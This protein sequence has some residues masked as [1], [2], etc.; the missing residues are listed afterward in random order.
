MSVMLSCIEGSNPTF[1]S[2]FATRAKFFLRSGAPWSVLEIETLD[3][4]ILDC[5]GCG[6][7][8]SR[9]PDKQ[10]IQEYIPRCLE[11]VNG[12]ADQ[13]DHGEEM[14]DPP[15]EIFEAGVED[16]RAF[17]KSLRKHRGDN[18]HGGGNDSGTT[19]RYRKK[20]CVVGPSSW[21]KT[22]LIKSLTTNIQT[23]EDTDKRTIGVD[24]F[25]W[26]FAK[27]VPTTGTSA[28]RWNHRVYDVSIWDFAGQDEYQS[29]HTLCYSKRT[30]Y[31]VCI[32]V[33][34][35]ADVLLGS[36]PADIHHD[37]TV[38]AFFDANI[39]SRMRAICV[40]EPES[41]FAFVGT[42]L[43]LITYSRDTIDR[44]E[45]DVT[46]RLAARERDVLR[47]LKEAIVELELEI[48]ETARSKHA[49]DETDGVGHG[50]GL[51]SRIAGLT[52]LQTKR[53]RIL[54]YQLNVMSSRNLTGADTVRLALEDLIVSS[55]TSFIMPPDFLELSAYIHN[56][57]QIISTQSVK[58]QIDTLF[59][60]VDALHDELRAQP[61]FASLERSDI[62]A[63]LRALHVIGDILWFDNADSLLGSTLFLSPALIIDF[64]RKIVNHQLGESDSDP[65][66]AAVRD[67]G[68]VAHALLRSLELWREVHDERLMLQLKS[69]LL[70]FQLAYPDGSSG[71][72]WNSDLIVPIY[73]KKQI[74]TSNCENLE[75]PEDAITGALGERVCWEYEFP[76]EL[77][78]SLFEKLG[79]ASYS[80]HFPCN[81]S[82]SSNAF[83]TTRVGQY[84]AKISKSGIA[85]GRGLLRVTVWA[86]TLTDAWQQLIWYAL[87]IE[88]LLETYL[89]LW[90]TRVAVSRA[91]KRLDIER[92]ITER[93]EAQS[94]SS[95]ICFRTSNPAREAIE[96]LPP[97]IDWY[98]NKS[99]RSTQRASNASKVSLIQS[100]GEAII[101]YDRLEALMV[102]TTL[103][104]ESKFGSKLDKHT[105]KVVY[106][107]NGIH[108]HVDNATQSLMT[109]AAGEGNRREYPALWSLMYDQSNVVKATYELQIRSQL[110]GR[111]FQPKRII[112]SVAGA[113]FGKYGVA[114]NVSCLGSISN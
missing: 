36:A 99:W 22:S 48:D 72:K 16:I 94:L 29:V 41:E 89:G 54:S 8:E 111:C 38:D 90:V 73:W 76:T 33:K 78:K 12:W 88:R 44:I 14:L 25:T 31:V 96:L 4:A 24:L 114:I 47:Q 61:A 113:V 1:F 52:A 92:L 27:S 9:I 56:K 80:A 32:N 106:L 10:R 86:S 66:H 108:T 104:I 39:Y 2:S 6:P 75:P 64:V 15:Q 51:S 59:V 109:Q 35:Y 17:F 112:I 37:A 58:V 87:N 65:L 74:R 77:P 98:I 103:E 83:A 100:S 45:A 62:M 70:Q 82:Y 3:P 11:V 81:R 53:P 84:H 93:I 68:R 18:E 102:K 42:K 21:G 91:G 34:A 50:I 55:N 46:Q 95:T 7:Y 97:V 107:A 79:V 71:L 40:H 63:M 30:L 13:H 43:D 105:A 67:E 5:L 69:L 28:S 19:S 85:G 20:I 23:L 26:K 49:S 110:S 57:V 101:S 60:N